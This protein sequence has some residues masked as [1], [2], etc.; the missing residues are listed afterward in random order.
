MLSHNEAAN[1]PRCLGALRDCDEIVA[2]DDGSTDDSLRCG[3]GLRARVVHHPFVDFA[4]A[5]LGDGGSEPAP[6]DWFRIWMPTR[7]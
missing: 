7:S 3:G 4:P 5:E 6:R 2:V 1:L